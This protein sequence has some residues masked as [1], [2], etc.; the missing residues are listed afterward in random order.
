MLK[1]RYSNRQEI[2]VLF[3]TTDSRTTSSRLYVVGGSVLDTMSRREVTDP[4]VV[5]LNTVDGIMLLSIRARMVTVRLTDVLV[6]YLRQ[7]AL[8][9]GHLTIGIWSESEET[10][11]Q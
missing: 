5:L 7:N 2:H 4:R 9:K 11:T 10:Y 8:R 1:S 3:P 6:V